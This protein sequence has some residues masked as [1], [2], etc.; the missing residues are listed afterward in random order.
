MRS[1]YY[2]STLLLI[3][4]GMTV[5]FSCTADPDEAFNEAIENL[6]K[7]KAGSLL[8]VEQQFIKQT[9]VK[10]FNAQGLLFS[11]SI[12]CYRDQNMFDVVYPEKLGIPVVNAGNKI[13][14]DI[15]DKYFIS[16]DEI[17]VS[18]VNRKEDQQKIAV[19]G[20]KKHP[21]KALVLC[22]DSIIYYRNYKVYLFDIRLN[23]TSL[24][25]ANDFKPKYKNYN[26][27]LRRKGK[28][29][30]VLIGI[31][32]DH[33]LS[34]IDIHEKKI[35]IEKIAAAS[36][37]IFLAEEYV[38]YVMGSSGKWTITKFTIPDKQKWFLNKLKDIRDIVL[39]EKGFLLEDRKGLW[40][41]DYKN[42]KKYLPFK[43]ELK[44]KSC[45]NILFNYKNT[46]HL[47]DIST[48]F[49]KMESLMKRSPELFELWRYDE[50]FLKKNK[51]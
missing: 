49:A 9:Q 8:A 48:L 43:Y 38:L 51:K 46:I 19:L 22:D 29:L 39:L 10:E 31:G 3:L 32:G 13:F 41:M 42:K 21:V 20:D 25:I 14:Y 11:G 36:S 12:M 40:A 6:N 35:K 18:I 15:N 44:G 33:S 1:Y 47:V 4:L 28:T 45:G 34:L 37:R 23:K 16:S 27:T 24:L 5:A 50:K 7:G 26:V 2:I 30:A 17:K